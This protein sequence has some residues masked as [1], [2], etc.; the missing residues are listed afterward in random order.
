MNFNEIKVSD[1]QP[2]HSTGESADTRIRRAWSLQMPDEVKAK[3]K[4]FPGSVKTQLYKSFDLEVNEIWTS[5][6]AKRNEQA[7]ESGAKEVRVGG[8]RRLQDE[9][10]QDPDQVLIEAAQ[11]FIVEFAKREANSN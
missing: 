10:C 1:L 9:F 5:L 3:F 8:Y 4:D 7:I 2:K 6:L 11:Q